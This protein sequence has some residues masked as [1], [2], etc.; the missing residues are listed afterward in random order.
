MYVNLVG[1]AVAGEDGMAQAGAAG[2]EE[3]ETQNASKPGR[4]HTRPI[5][6]VLVSSA[7]VCV[8][9]IHYL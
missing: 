6:S 4:V 5:V 9:H 2:G 3:E 7:K 1:V 8:S